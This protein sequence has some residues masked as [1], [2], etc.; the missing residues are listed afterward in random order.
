MKIPKKNIVK[1]SVF[2]KS[3]VD[4]VI[5]DEFSLVFFIIIFIF[6]LTLVI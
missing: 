4:K 2:L 1:N 5:N 6:Y 3:V